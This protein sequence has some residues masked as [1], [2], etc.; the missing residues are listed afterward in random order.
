MTTTT[1]H[2]QG[3]SKGGNQYGAYQVRYASDRQVMFI[4]TL[5]EQKAHAYNEGDIDFA[6][7]NVQGAK[8]VISHLL[9]LP[10]KEGYKYPPSEK[11]VSYVR[12]LSTQKEGGLELLNSTLL[13]HNAKDIMDL[14]RNVVA[15]LITNLQAL[16]YQQPTVQD[17]G[18]YLYDG[19][20]YSIRKGRES[21][22]WQV[23][24]Y[25]KELGK[26][27]IQPHLKK[28]LFVITPEHRLTL[29]EAIQRSVQTGQ[30]VHCGRTL[31]KQKSVVG[32]MGEVCAK[33]YH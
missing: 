25:D 9:T 5:L 1:T 11:Q 13:N 16:S 28:L 8:D 14:D 6:T 3:G 7:L 12:S 4:K 26:Y 33:K 31:T 29:S 27:E 32:G 23:W 2:R 20:V 18:A 15:Q 10:L 30:C 24:A 17:V 21:G 22:K 19:V